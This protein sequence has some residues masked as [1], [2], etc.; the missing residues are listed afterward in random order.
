MNMSDNQRANY[1][2]CCMTLQHMDGLWNGA[3]CNLSS[4]LPLCE[5]PDLSNYFILHVYI[6]KKNG[7]AHSSLYYYIYRCFCKYDIFKAMLYYTKA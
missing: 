1:D 6:A 2:G 5:N 7:Y 3:H 4:S